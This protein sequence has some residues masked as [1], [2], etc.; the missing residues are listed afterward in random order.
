VICVDRVL[1]YGPARIYARGSIYR[2]FPLSARSSEA[3][4]LISF[5]S[6]LS[7]YQNAGTEI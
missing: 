2:M 4:C 3:E 7:F 6:M 5:M 1:R